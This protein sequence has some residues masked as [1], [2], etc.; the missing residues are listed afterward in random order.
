ML[1]VTG[2][3]KGKVYKEDI[4][5]ADQLAEAFGVADIFEERAP[6]TGLFETRTLTFKLNTENPNVVK[7]NRADGKLRYP[8]AYQLTTFINGFFEGAN[9]Q[10]RYYRSKVNGGPNLRPRYSPARLR[11]NGK[12][13][14]IN[15][16]RDKEEA[17]FWLLFPHCKDSPLHDPKRHIAAYVL[18]DKEKM[19][20]AKFQRE[21]LELQLRSSIMQLPDDL[22]IQIALG[23]QVG[24]RTIPQDEAQ[25][26]VSAKV[27]LIELAKM[28]PQAVR[29]AMSSKGTMIDGAIVLAK[30]RGLIHI[31]PGDNQ[32]N[33][34][35][36]SDSLGGERI[37]GLPAKGNPNK[38]L[39][40]YLSSREAWINFQEITGITETEAKISEAPPV[41][42]AAEEVS[43]EAAIIQE[44]LANRC[45]VLHP[46][47]DKIYIM[48]PSGH[49]QDRALLVVKDRKTWKEE[50]LN[51]ANRAIA[52]RVKKRLEEGALAV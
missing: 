6:T 7:R 35:Y 38:E 41:E 50:L 46:T 40:K 27:A 48:E 37:I 2:T 43:E 28:N 33:A 34:W 9:L 23:I 39:A 13:K 51:R 8:T 45:I 26:A 19:A 47:E 1:E 16:A 4:L 14:P 24:R 20:Q 21:S 49:F 10:I 18:E 12:A 44:G 31:A 42:E 29:D 5:T 22:A 30:R 32:K 25:S 11:M 52:G 3:L 36:Y 15:L 17:L